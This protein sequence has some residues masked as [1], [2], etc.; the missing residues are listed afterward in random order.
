[1]NHVERK[2]DNNNAAEIV[3]S[4]FNSHYKVMKGFQIRG[5]AQAHLTKTV[6]TIVVS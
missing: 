2:I 3:F 1:M 4:L 5:G 6:L